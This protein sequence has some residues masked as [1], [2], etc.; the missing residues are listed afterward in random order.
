MWDYLSEVTPDY[1]DD[2]LDVKRH[3]QITEEGSKNQILHLGDDNS[4]EVISF[5]DDTIFYV[6]I[7]WELLKEAEAGTIYDFYHD[8]LKA[9]GMARSFKW[10]HYGEKTDQHTYTVRFVSKMSR[11]LKSW[12]I[13]GIKNIRLK[14][15]GRAPS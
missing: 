13:H 1:L 11:D 15:L 5:S 9:N 3:V 6:N 2:T 4:E 8:P 7:Q 10:V 14:V 12:D